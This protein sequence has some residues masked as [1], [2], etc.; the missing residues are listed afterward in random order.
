[1][2]NRGIMLNKFV[3]LLVSLF[4]TT[5]VLAQTDPNAK[6]D[7]TLIPETTKVSQ[8]QTFSVSLMMSAQTT[9]QRYL[10]A[11]IIFAWD[12]NVLEFVD[13]SHEGSHPLIW[14]PPSGM[15]CP[16]DYTECAGIGGDY[17]GINEAIPPA[18]GNGLYY[19]YGEL[20]QV[21]IVTEP[22][23]IVKFIFKVIAPFETTQISL[24]PQLTVTWPAE[25][26]VYGSYIPGLDTLGNINN[27]TVEFSQPIAGD[28]NSDGFV[29][30]AD[31]GMLL[32]NWGAVSFGENPYDLSGNGIVDGSDLAILF[33]NWQK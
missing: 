14:V 13:V 18:D 6:I 30:S 33:G 7:L 12:H 17:T 22:V 31:L 25:T 26:V 32:A 3:T 16:E 27:A 5:S 10:V 9:P 28:F 23:Q 2:G 11:D 4:I 24:L 19:G 29:N 1:M 15:P 20:G 21:F 8:G